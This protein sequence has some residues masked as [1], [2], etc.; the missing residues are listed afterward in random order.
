VFGHTHIN[1]NALIDGVHY[2][3]LALKVCLYC[4]HTQQ[5]TNIHLLQYP[6]ERESSRTPTD[7][8]Q[9][10]IFSESEAMQDQYVAMKQRFQA[11]NL[12]VY[13]LPGLQN[14]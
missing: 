1:W 8:E 3:Q 9:L 4:A 7:M 12:A 2:I 6:K 13:E 5:R 11:H 10:L 14:K